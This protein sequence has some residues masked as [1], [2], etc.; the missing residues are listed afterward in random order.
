MISS[1]VETR[2]K[3]TDHSRTTH[4][5]HHLKAPNTH[6][7]MGDTRADMPTDAHMHGKWTHPILD[8]NS[9]LMGKSPICAKLGQSDPQCHIGIQL[10]TCL[11]DAQTVLPTDSR[12]RTVAL[13]VSIH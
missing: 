8:K 5:P 6:L 9:I 2:H 1:N 3:V 7:S 10:S 13:W 4:K 11:E 12:C